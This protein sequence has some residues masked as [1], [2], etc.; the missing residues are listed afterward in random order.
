MA[1]KNIQNDSEIPIEWTKSMIIIII[2][3]CGENLF[4]KCERFMR[5]FL[6]IY[7]NHTMIYNH[8]FQSQRFPNIENPDTNNSVLM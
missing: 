1:N 4:A 3:A 5:T 8:A 7:R 2:I 6:D